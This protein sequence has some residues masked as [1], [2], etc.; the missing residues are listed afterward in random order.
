VFIVTPRLAKPMEAVPALP[1]DHYVQPSRTE[2]LLGGQH[3]GKRAT[4]TSKE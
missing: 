2:F 1:T 4:S 3:E